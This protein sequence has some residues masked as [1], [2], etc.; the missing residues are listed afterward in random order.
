M[1]ETTIRALET[2]FAEFA[3]GKEASAALFYERLF[4]ND[5]S[6]RSMFTSTDMRAQQ[7]KLMAALGLVVGKLRTLGDVVPVLQGLAV[8]H[9]AYGVEEHHYETVG[10]AL[11]QS[12]ALT[13]G[14]R[15]TPD[16]RA[17]WI[18]A[19]GAV[20]GVM[21]DAARQA[22]MPGVAAE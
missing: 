6:L 16:L 14:S 3:K 5:P 4:V 13:F 21:I 20:S 8:K 12:L 15:F 10:A 19:Y 17:A 7:I 1:D 22:Q 11:I 2:S 9:V 18:G